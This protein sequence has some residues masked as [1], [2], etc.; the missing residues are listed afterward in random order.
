M[1][2]IM[3]N[4]HSYFIFENKNGVRKEKNIYFMIIIII[5][6]CFSII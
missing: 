1:A 3:K 6:I 2:P 5:I 4:L